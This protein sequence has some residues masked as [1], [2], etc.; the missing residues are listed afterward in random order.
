VS[1]DCKCGSGLPATLLRYVV[2]EGGITAV[3][4]FCSECAQDRVGLVWMK[5]SEDEN[6]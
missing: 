4:L 5:K 6:E 1:P 3:R 2:L